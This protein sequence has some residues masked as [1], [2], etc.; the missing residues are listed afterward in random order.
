MKL[1]SVSNLL[2]IALL[3]CLI[4]SAAFFIHDS[5]AAYRVSHGFQRIPLSYNPTE[6][7]SSYPFQGAKLTVYGGFIKGTQEEKGHTAVVVRALSP[8][9]AIEV[10][11]DTAAELTILLENVN[12]DFY[13]SSISAGHVPAAKVA[14]NTLRLT[15]PV[16]VGQATAVSPEQPAEDTTGKY[17]YVVL[18]DNRDS[19]D[20]FGQMLDQ[21]NGQNPVFVI[22]NGDLVFSGKANQYRLF[23]N[24]ISRLGTTLCTTLGNH[25]IRGDGRDT[26]TMLYGPAYYSFDFGSSHYTFLDSSP[27]WAEKTSISAEQYT[28]LE[29][30]LQK[31]QGKQIFVITH[32]PPRDPRAGVLPNNI[33]GYMNQAKSGD[34]FAEQMLDNYNNN[35]EIDHG[36][37]DP[38]EAARFETLMRT[39]HVDTVYLSHIH[40]YME[41][42]RD[43]VRYLI[44]GGAGAE[45]LTENSY[46]HYMVTKVG[47]AGSM[48]M[49]ELPSPPSNYIS[50]YG[51]VA[52]LFAKALYRENPI[53]VG[54]VLAGL[55][56]FG[57]LLLLKLYLSKKDFLHKVGRLIPAVVRYA[58]ET[59]R[60]Q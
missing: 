28:W 22:D 29:Q 12:P 19:Y 57:V 3:A 18:G 46:Y 10:T 52:Q 23:D 32:I 33:P 13:A 5:N 42:E 59:W 27:G 54:L 21:V 11:G 26:Y 60:Q 20:I 39:Y 41:Y 31:A 37:Q 34:N 40:S 8:L 6:N 58:K 49:V 35:K 14:A 53:A 24:M 56:L 50:R 48:T 44:T 7:S 55:V 4:G 9:P 47:D 38:E 2:L 1:K 51:A 25:D 15:V 17:K 43:G 36:F 16:K 30:D 45:L